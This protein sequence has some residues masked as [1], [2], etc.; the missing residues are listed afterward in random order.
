M[1]TYRVKVRGTSFLWGGKGIKNTFV[2]D[3]HLHFRLD[4]T[5]ETITFGI[6][7]SSGGSLI[8]QGTLSPGETFTIK[9]SDLIGVYAQTES[10]IHT[11]VDCALVALQE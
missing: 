4:E 1:L 3:I 6:I 11:Y 9:L 5:G 7:K 2:S 8:P 10:S